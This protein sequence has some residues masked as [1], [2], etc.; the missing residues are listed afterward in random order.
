MP[1]TPG[2]APRF[3]AWNAVRDEAP[4]RVGFV[5]S[6]RRTS[7]SLRPD[8]V[9]DAYRQP[10]LLILVIVDDGSQR[11]RLAIAECD[12]AI[13]GHQSETRFWH[14]NEALGIV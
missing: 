11:S 13:F 4:Q 3:I 12:N 10:A 8:L 14:V 1:S 9:F 5:K 6:P 2:A 7:S